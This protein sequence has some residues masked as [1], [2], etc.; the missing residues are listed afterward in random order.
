MRRFRCEFGPLTDPEG[1]SGQINGKQLFIVFVEHW[2]KR[3]DHFVSCS[4][5]AFVGRDDA[6]LEERPISAS[7][8][9][10]SNFHAGWPKELEETRS[11]L[12]PASWVVLG[13]ADAWVCVGERSLTR[14][15]GDREE[16]KSIKVE[17]QLESIIEK[18]RQQLVTC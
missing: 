15:Q 7:A 14:N 17:K 13:C 4:F 5:L 12:L 18:R 9:N 10:Q 6:D 3:T 2:V 8:T 11:H 16:K 1:Q